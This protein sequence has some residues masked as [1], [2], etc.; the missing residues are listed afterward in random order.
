MQT[1]TLNNRNGRDAGEDVNEIILAENETWADFDKIVKNYVSNFKIA[2]INANSVGGFK[3]YEIKAWLLS[4]R[5]DLLVIS[6]SKIDASF[7]DKGF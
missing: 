7:P 5:L 4:G 1:P 6:E 3:F 2:H